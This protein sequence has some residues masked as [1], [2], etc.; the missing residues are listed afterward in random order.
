MVNDRSFAVLG[1]YDNVAHW[2]NVTQISRNTTVRRI[3][4]QFMHSKENEN[5]QILIDTPSSADLY[6]LAPRRATTTKLRQRRRW[7]RRKKIEN[8]TII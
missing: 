2:E 5:Q 6:E 3:F 8:T 4:F 1:L 7:R